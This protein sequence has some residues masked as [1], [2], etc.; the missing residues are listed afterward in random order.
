MTLNVLYDHQIFSYQK[1][2]GISRYFTEILH[3]IPNHGVNPILTM[4]NNKNAHLL[5]YKWGREI[6]IENTNRVDD[7]FKKTNNFTNDMVVKLNLRG[8][9]YCDVFHPTYYNPY[10][11]KHV[12]KKPYV[13]T[14]HDMIHELFPEQNVEGDNTKEWKR[15]VLSGATRLIA[16]SENMKEDIQKFYDIDPNIIDV[17]YHG[18]SLEDVREI[19]SV[20]NSDMVGDIMYVDNDEVCNGHYIE[21]EKD[22]NDWY[23]HWLN[24][25]LFRKRIVL[26]VGSRG[27]YKNFS[28]FI[29]AMETIIKKYDDIKI[30]CFGGGKFTDIEKYTIHNYNLTKYVVWVSGDDILL[31]FIYDHTQLFVFPSLYEGFGIPILE[32]FYSGCTLLLSNRSCFPEIAGDA[33]IYFEPDETGEAKDLI[34]KID[35]YLSELVSSG[36]DGIFKYKWNGCERI[37]NFSWKKSAEQTVNVYKKCLE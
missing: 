25:D 16:V 11:L 31:K 17:V 2:G 1:Y 37:K 34:E 4:Y 6:K 26:F 8:K 20:D 21:F 28:E 24:K 33:A 27:G 36:T 35:G 10:F 13:I 7:F 23:A 12:G 14:V 29:K 9:E 32:A 3:E 18:C 22:T 5:N 15:Q 30:I 19:Y